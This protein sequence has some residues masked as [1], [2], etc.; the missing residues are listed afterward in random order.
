MTSAERALRVLTPLRTPGV[1]RGRETPVNDPEELPPKKLV[2]RPTGKQ[3]DVNEMYEHVMRRFPKTMAR[4]AEIEA[5]E[6]S[7]RVPSPRT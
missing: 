3:P 4:L 1:I 7:R 2:P 6:D 5:S